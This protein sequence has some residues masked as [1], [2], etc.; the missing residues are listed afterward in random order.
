MTTRTMIVKLTR[1]ISPPSAMYMPFERDA[2]ASMR[3]HQASALAPV[4]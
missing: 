3:R 2:A 4:M 1:A